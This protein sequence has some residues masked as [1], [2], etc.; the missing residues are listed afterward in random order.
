MRTRERSEKEKLKNSDERNGEREVVRSA[1]G[2][3]RE[4]NVRAQW[5]RGGKGSRERARERLREESGA[6]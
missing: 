2:V 4:E 6:R 5:P 3:R 1:E